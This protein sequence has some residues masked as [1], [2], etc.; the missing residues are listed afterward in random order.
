MEHYVYGQLAFVRAQTLKLM[1][2]VTEA[3]ADVVPEGFRNHIR[4]HLGHIY[5]VLDRYAHKYTELP[6][7]APAGWTALFEYGTSPLTAPAD[8]AWP[9]LREL[10][11]RLGGQIERI[12]LTFGED[13]G[14]PVVSPYT[15]SAGMHLGTLEQ[16]FSFNLY[17]EAMHL[18]TIRNYRKLLSL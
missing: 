18:S 7:Q 15:T 2:G 3:Q 10:E 8:A 4:W 16:F 13:I 1:E 12:R 11:E 14:Q 9:S 5:V 6:L 17:H